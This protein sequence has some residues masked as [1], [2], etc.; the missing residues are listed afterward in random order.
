MMVEKTPDLPSYDWI[1]LNSSGGKDSQ[2]ML[3]H[4]CD[5]AREK[6]I[7]TQRLVIAHA[8]LEEEWPGTKELAAE[9]ARHYG[10]RFEVVRRE[11][12]GL[13][14]HVRGRRRTLDAGGRTDAPAWMAPGIAR[15]CTS[16]HKRGPIRTLFTRLVE[17]TRKGRGLNPRGRKG[18]PVRILNCLGMRADESSCRAKLLPFS[19]CED[20]TNGR[21]QVWDWLP[22]HEWSVEQVWADIHRRGVPHHWAYDIGMSRLSCCFC[23]YA[24]YEALLLSGHYN[25]AL[26]R[27]YVEVEREV[28][29]TFKVDLSLEKVLKDV[30]AGVRPGPVKSWEM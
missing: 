2:T 18:E 26:L 19:V 15:F 3:A 9:Q 16:D 24:P 27:K 12:G 25:T 4:V 10:L 8:E 29:S 20:E 28:R 1:V 11:Q 5:Q 22:I 7:P 6:K 17:E 21:K 23:I 14:E 30:E 13:L